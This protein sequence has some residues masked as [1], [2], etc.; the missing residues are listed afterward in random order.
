LS[1]PSHGTGHRGRAH[2]HRTWT[3]R[4]RG[5]P[6]GRTAWPVS[7]EARSSRS[8]T[9]ALP[10]GSSHETWWTTFGLAISFLH[11]NCADLLIW[12]PR[13]RLQPQSEI[14]RPLI[15]ACAPLSQSA[16][17]PTSLGRGHLCAYSGPFRPLVP[18]ESVHPFRVNSSTGSG[19]IRPPFRS[20]SSTVPGEFVQVF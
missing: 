18:I 2:Q 4:E 6:S 7:G 5:R 9:R 19:R 1:H 11:F 16:H 15:S 14:R 20:N 10:R 13:D 17:W 3:W 8:R 12:S